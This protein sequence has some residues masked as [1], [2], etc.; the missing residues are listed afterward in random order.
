MEELAAWERRHPARIRCEAHLLTVRITHSLATFQM[1]RRCV[2]EGSGISGGG[3]ARFRAGEATIQARISATGGDALFS[4]SPCSPTRSSLAWPET[5]P[6][7]RFLKRFGEPRALAPGR[8]IKWSWIDSPSH[9]EA[10]EV[11]VVKLR[12]EEQ[13]RQ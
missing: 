3:P 7:L 9:P 4:R 12:E 1:R 11:Q 8:Y 5:E 10:D 2:D 6:R 13:H